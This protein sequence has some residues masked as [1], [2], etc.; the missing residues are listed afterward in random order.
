MTCIVKYQAHAGMLLLAFAA[1]LMA[2][3]QESTGL[4]VTGK[5]PSAL[6]FKD[7]AIAKAVRETLAE[8][9][10]KEKDKNRIG[11]TSANLAAHAPLRADR[12]DA[13][14]QQFS[15]AQV[16][17]CIGPDPLKHVPTS[18]VIRSKT[19]GDWVVGVGGIFAAPF[20]GYAALTG[21]CR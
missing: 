9:K 11:T 13:F 14:G 19:L 10:D 12:Y 2:V 6:Q 3:A 15:A 20:W 17:R 7:E 1:S 21:K 8:S 4:A 18:T 16:P 5:I